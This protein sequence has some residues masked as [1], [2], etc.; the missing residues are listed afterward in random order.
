MDIPLASDAVTRFAG[1]VSMGLRGT[2]TI[3]ESKKGR[4]TLIADLRFL[5]GVNMG[6]SL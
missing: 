3:L 1:E 4:E 6:G 5:L 2:A